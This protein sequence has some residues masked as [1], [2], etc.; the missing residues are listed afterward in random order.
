MTGQSLI[1]GTGMGLATL[2]SQAF[3]AKNY[4]RVGVLWQ[5]QCVYQWLLC[6]VVAAIWWHTEAILLSFGQPPRVAANAA[7]WARW[8]LPGLPA[9][10]SECSDSCPSHRSRG[11]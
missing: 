11:R 5:R 2:S 1:Y 9:M 10:P 8:Q 4:R 7:T 3:G 6:V